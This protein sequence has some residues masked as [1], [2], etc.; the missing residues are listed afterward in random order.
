MAG[1][2]RSKSQHGSRLLS[3]LSRIRTDISQLAD[4][5]D[6]AAPAPALE[7]LS[8]MIRGELLANWVD[9]VVAHKA[10]RAWLR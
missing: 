10:G 7:K 3:I 1:K 5:P 4:M 8:G 2:R 9:S 6:P